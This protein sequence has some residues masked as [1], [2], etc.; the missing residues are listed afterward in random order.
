MFISI[1]QEVLMKRFVVTL[2]SLMVVIPVIA[3]AQG[4]PGWGKMSLGV[5]GEVSIPVGDYSNIA[6]TG[7]GGNVRFQY[8]SDT[9]TAFT[10]TA[11]YLVWGK[12]EYAGG[13]SGQP[14][15]FN[16]FLGGKYYF[17]EGF[18]GTLEGGVYFVTYNY[19]GALVGATGDGSYFMLPIGIG[20]QKSGFEVGVRYMLYHPDLNNF[21]ITVGYNFAL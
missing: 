2:L 17:T 5:T 13:I 12:K 8:G 19:T 10:A 14:K 6:G 7:Y 20:Y 21:S 4:E 16:L 9:R 15:A 11:G 18:Y 1:L 3:Y